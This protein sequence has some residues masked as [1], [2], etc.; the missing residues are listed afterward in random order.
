MQ[1]PPRFRV[2]VCLLKGEGM[3]THNLPPGKV[4]QFQEGKSDDSSRKAGRPPKA[5]NVLRFRQRESEKK[6]PVINRGSRPLHARRPAVAAP[7]LTT[8]RLGFELFC[9]MNRIVARNDRDEILY[10]LPLLR[11]RQSAEV[12]EEL[13]AEIVKLDK[14]TCCMCG[15]KI[16]EDEITVIFDLVPGRGGA[17]TASNLYT[18]CYYCAGSKGG[19]T[20]TEYLEGPP[21][22]PRGGRNPF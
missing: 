12:S 7:P 4:L 1:T 17:H 5:K 22:V 14:S 13:K 20:I 2:N 9:R 8:E 6:K 18:A 21:I 15:F 10:W 19:K 11:D 16:S 3:T